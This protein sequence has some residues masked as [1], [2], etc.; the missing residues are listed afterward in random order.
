MSELKKIAEI[1]C[2]HA[3]IDLKWPNTHTHT[4]TYTYTHTHTHAKYLLQFC[5]SAESILQLDMDV[6]VGGD[7]NDANEHMVI[8]AHSVS[9]TFI[10][11]LDT[12]VSCTPNLSLPT[13]SRLLISFFN[14]S[15][16]WEDILWSQRAPRHVNSTLINNTVSNCNHKLK[17]TVQVILNVIFLHQSIII[18]LSKRRTI[19]ENYYHQLSFD[20]GFVFQLFIFI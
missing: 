13:N 5:G 19:H 4:H 1:N 8:R 14:F 6:D 17:L 9:P 15:K 20:K 12:D 10:I 11:Q 7:S 3:K 18:Q 16:H 2:V